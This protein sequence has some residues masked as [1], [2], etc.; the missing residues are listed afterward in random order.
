MKTLVV[1]LLLLA[2]SLA[3]TQCLA[4]PAGGTDCTGPLRIKQPSNPTTAWSFAPETAAFACPTGATIA[5]W[6]F[7][8]HNGELEVDY[9]QGYV[10]LKGDKGDT[11]PR[12]AT[13][14]QGPQ[15]QTGAQGLTGSTGA[16]GP[17]GI[18]GLSG[19]Q[20]VQGI[21]GVPGIVVGSSGTLILTC[22]GEAQHS[23]PL[24]FS[25]TCT[26][27]VTGIK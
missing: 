11:G 7:C 1:T 17:Q 15:G 23:I 20:G 18:Q 9:G 26:F 3:Y 24:G 12:G 22:Q 25:T 4:N 10:S 16:T 2:S 8:G 13:G 5:S 19:A 21:Q 27:K 6:N 14:L